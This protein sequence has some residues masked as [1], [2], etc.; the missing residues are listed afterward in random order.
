MTDWLDIPVAELPRAIP[1]WKRG[2]LGV[3]DRQ[4]QILQLVALG[5]HNKHIARIL[6]ISVRTAEAIRWQMYDRTGIR[7]TVQII[8]AADRLFRQVQP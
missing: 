2:R 5:N 8:I 6:G 3:T 1:A 7:N 4:L